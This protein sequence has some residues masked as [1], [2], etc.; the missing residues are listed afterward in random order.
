MDIVNFEG[1]TVV[2]V[3]FKGRDELSTVLD[4]D[5]PGL[6]SDPERYP[7]CKDSLRCLL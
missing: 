7:D 1:V 2:P 6:P 3:Y 5:D 4:T